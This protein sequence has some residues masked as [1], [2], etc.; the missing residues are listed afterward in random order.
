MR[1]LITLVIVLLAKAVDAQ[2]NQATSNSA[3]L[4]L[5]NIQVFPIKD[6]ENGRAY[7]LFIKLPESYLENKA[8]SYPVIYYTD[9]MW[10]IEMLSGST[11]YLLEQAILVGVSWQIDIDEQLK[12]ETG[13][14]VSRF[15]DYTVQPSDNPDHQ[16]K[17][18]FGQA[19]QHLNFIQ[20]DVIPY[21]EKNYRIDPDNNTYF[22]YSLGG[23]FGAY[24]L[25][26]Q[27]DTFKNYIL[28]SPSLEGDIPYLTQLSSDGSSSNFNANVFISY[29]DQEEK[30]GKLAE[31]FITLLNDRND[32]SLSL[33]KQV[34]EGTH[35]TAF[36]LTVVN[37]I[38]WLANLMK[39]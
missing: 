37:S 24:I 23:L 21:V 20:N 6:L 8:T 31:D 30:L 35:Q 18:K 22:G 5:P 2:D 10:H 26:A 19:I 1:I 39:E 15:R 28:G 3:N 29:G 9:V 33:T 13:E 32:T 12:L 14:H 25:L 11:E 7:N 16:K 34:I 4:E 36:P 27:P 17:Y 38:T